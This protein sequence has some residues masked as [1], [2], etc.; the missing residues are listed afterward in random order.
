MDELLQ[1]LASMGLGNVSP[2]QLASLLSPEEMALLKQTD[3]LSSLRAQAPPSLSSQRKTFDL[4]EESFKQERKQDIERAKKVLEASRRYL[5]LP[6]A[7]QIHTQR[8]LKATPVPIRTLPRRMIMK[9]M[10]DNINFSR[11]SS[12]YEFRQTFDD[13]RSRFSSKPLSQLEQMSISELSVPRHHEGSW[14]SP[15]A[16]CPLISIYRQIPLLSRRLQNKP[17]GLL[18]VV[19]VSRSMK[20]RL[21]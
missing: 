13:G 6:R 8:E 11:P 9:T 15:L 20:H 14:H 18:Y 5:P 3:G 7:D 2:A 19:S 4:D 1:K 16:P 21:A 17:G 12:K 10:Q